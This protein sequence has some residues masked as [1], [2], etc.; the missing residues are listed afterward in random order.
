MLSLHHVK[1]TSLN[2]PFFLAFFSNPV[3]PTQCKEGRDIL[4]S[5]F[6]LY[7]SFRDLMQNANYLFALPCMQRLQSNKEI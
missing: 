2:E 5:L 7:S 4:Q 6:T 3:A 1:P